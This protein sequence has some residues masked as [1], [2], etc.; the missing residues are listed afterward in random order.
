MNEMRDLLLEISKETGFDP[1]E[2]IVERTASYV[3]KRVP[4]LPDES[5]PDWIRRGIVLFEEESKKL[6]GLETGDGSEA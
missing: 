3:S 6:A 4:K 5:V 1:S 2:E